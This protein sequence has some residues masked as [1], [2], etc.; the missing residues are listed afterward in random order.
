MDLPRSFDAESLPLFCDIL[1]R[2]DKKLEA[3]IQHFGYPPCWTR[4]P[5]FETLVYIILEQQVSLASAKAAFDKLKAILPVVTPEGFLLLDDATLKSCYFSRQKIVYARHLA[6]SLLNEDLDLSQFPTMS[7]EEIR[8]QL[9]KVKGIGN[10]TIDVYL[11]MALHR[12]DL[13][14][15]GDVALIKSLKET[16]QVA[17][18]VEREALSQVV[19]KWHPYQTIAA[20]LLWHSYLCRRKKK[21]QQSPVPVV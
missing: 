20:F 21:D 13:F 3:I 8:A 16:R 6:T 4:P 1:A 7:N 19:L 12:T 14:P 11:M 9:I 17:E 5:G 18:S 2:R 15:L 10:W